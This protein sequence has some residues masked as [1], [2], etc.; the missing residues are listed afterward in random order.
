MTPAFKVGEGDWLL[1]AQ[2]RCLSEQKFKDFDVVIIDPHYKKRVGYMGELAERY[3]LNL[4]H[5]PYRP[6][7]RVASRLDCAVFNAPYLFSESPRI[8]RYSCWRFV[9]PDFTRICVE[10]K[11]N[12]DFRF[13]SIQQ[14]NFSGKDDSSDTNHPRNIWDTGT[15]QVNWHNIPTKAGMGGA[16]WGADADV[17]APKTLMPLNAYGNYC[18]SRK[19]W[20]SIN[21]TDEVFTRT[22]H[23]ED[24]DFTLRAQN[25]GIKCERKAHVLYRLSHNYGTHSGRSNEPTDHP[26]T[27]NCPECEAACHVLEPKR[28]DLERRLLKNEIECF[29]EHKV[30]VCRKCLLS[31]PIYSKGCHEHTEWIKGSRRTQATIIRKHMTGRNLRILAA[32]MDGKNLQEKVEI[33]E[34]SYHEPCYYEP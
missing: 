11:T 30:W 13:H 12:V 19:D 34:R 10:S 26:L 3:K 24:M 5:I 23:Y 21:G 4:V 32:D 1:R 18:V 22:A 33:F 31:G 17:D 16:T 28:F 15:D 25:S 29:P 7:Q 6:N 20:L 27:K 14:P 8:V 9:R 2:L